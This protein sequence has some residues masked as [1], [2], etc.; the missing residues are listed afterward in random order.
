MAKIKTPTHL[1]FLDFNDTSANIW[2]STSTPIKK[3]TKQLPNIWREP[4]VR[5]SEK[6][7][8]KKP[9]SNFYFFFPLHRLGRK[10]TEASQVCSL[11][12]RSRGARQASSALWWLWVKR[13]MQTPAKKK[14]KKK[15]RTTTRTTHPSGKKALMILSPR[16]LIAN[17]GILWKSS[18]LQTWKMMERTCNTI[19]FK[20][21]LLYPCF[22]LQ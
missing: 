8:K 11:E 16:G 14:T 3:T 4:V 17:S 15:T 10:K 13:L 22:K 18:R 20:K 12:S 19:H 6:K 9:Q 7:K 21:K 2:F 5:C 1:T